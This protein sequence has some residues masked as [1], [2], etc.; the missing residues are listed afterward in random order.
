MAHAGNGPGKQKQGE[1][2]SYIGKEKPRQH[3]RDPQNLG[4]ANVD[5]ADDH[6]PHKEE[7]PHKADVHRGSIA[8]GGVVQAEIPGQKHQQRR[9]EQIDDVRQG[10]A[11][12][13]HGAG[14]KP[15]RGIQ[16]VFFHKLATAVSLIC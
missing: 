7:K 16:V 9:G 6:R 11:Q 5:F 14:D 10:A 13:I 2:F 15:I 1:T 3:Q 8:R 12:K 4:F